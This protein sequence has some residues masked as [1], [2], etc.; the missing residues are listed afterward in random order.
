MRHAGEAKAAFAM[1]VDHRLARQMRPICPK[2]L[3]LTSVV[4][5]S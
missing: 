1:G 4:I 5:T 3:F 2:E